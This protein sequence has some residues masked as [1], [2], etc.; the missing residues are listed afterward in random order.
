VR[1]LVTAGPTR[2]HFDPVRYFSNASSGR[3]GYAIARAARERGH[4]VILV[5]GPVALDPPDVTV[6]HVVTADQMLEACLAHFLECDAALMTA[7]VADWRPTKPLSRKAPK[8][9]SAMTLPMEPT[10][11]VCATL[12]EIK[13]HRVLIGFAVQDDHAHQRAEEKMRRKSCDAM[14]LNSI[15]AIGAAESTIEIKSG[16]SPW[17]QPITGAK[18]VLAAAVV[19]LAEQYV[20]SL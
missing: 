17:G 15:A 14:V 16:E 7:A 10:P 5:S 8:A 3:M 20:R 2:E 4:D 6:V 19:E 18:D 9:A 13:G 12:G 11:D 1:V